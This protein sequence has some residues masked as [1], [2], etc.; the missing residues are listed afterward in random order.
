MTFN[1]VRWGFP[2]TA[3][4]LALAAIPF[5]ATLADW[6]PKQTVTARIEAAAI[7][8]T[9]MA[10]TTIATADWQEIFFE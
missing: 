9:A 5:V 10:C 6:Q 7:C 8:P 3:A 2:N 4:I 1:L